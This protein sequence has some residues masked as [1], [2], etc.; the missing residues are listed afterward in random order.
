MLVFRGAALPL[1]RFNWR[2]A[3]IWRNDAVGAREKR[4]SN[5]CNSAVPSCLKNAPNLANLSTRCMSRRTAKYARYTH[6]HSSLCCDAVLH[7]S[8]LF[9]CAWQ[10][11]S[12]MEASC[13]IDLLSLAGTSF[14]SR[15]RTLFKH[16]LMR[17]D[18]AVASFA[19]NLSAIKTQST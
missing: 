11:I 19:R 7:G 4:N 13:A 14:V 17:L 8:E 6:T 5:A 9:I 2:W 1:S 3:K 10:V 12:R 18:R 16:R 15:A